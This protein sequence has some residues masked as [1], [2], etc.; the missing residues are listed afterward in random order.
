MEF[1]ILVDKTDTK[2]ALYEKMLAH[3]KGLLHRAFSVFIF[4][5]KNELLLQQRA[6]SKY[7]SPGLWTNSCCSHPRDG[8]DIITAGKRRLIEEMGFETNIQEIFTEKYCLQLE[9]NM[10]E[11][12]Y[13]H[14]LIGKYS[15]RININ[16]EEVNDFCWISIDNILKDISQNPNIYTKWFKL[17]LPELIKFYK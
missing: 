16:S 7:H 12:E 17:I 5:D 8:E 2:I 15:G 6:F 14:I 9:D 3:E 10:I 4:N 11:N 1:V 13:D